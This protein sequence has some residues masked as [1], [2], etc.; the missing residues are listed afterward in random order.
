MILSPA[1]IRSLCFFTLYSSSLRSWLQDRVPNTGL[2]SRTIGS[3]CLSQR[4]LSTIQLPF[5]ISTL[6]PRPPCVC[7]CHSFSLDFLY[8]HHLSTDPPRIQAQAQS[9]MVSTLAWWRSLLHPCSLPLNHEVLVNRG[10]GHGSNKHKLA[11]CL[12]SCRL[13]LFLFSVWSKAKAEWGSVG[14][15]LRGTGWALQDGWDSHGIRV[16]RPDI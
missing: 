3:P 14:L 5:S 13:Q 16:R 8:P 7:I 10:C 6:S 15:R 1:F 12:H 11:Y 2:P 4:T 9:S